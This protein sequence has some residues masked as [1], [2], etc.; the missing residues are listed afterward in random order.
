MIASNFP[1]G[2]YLVDFE[3][4]PAARREGNPP[5]PVCMVFRQWPSGDTKRYWQAGL[6]ALRA[7]PFPISSDAL[8]VAY[9]A[10]AE[11]DCFAALGW[12]YPAN[13][14]DL[15]AEFR[16]LTNGLRPA[17]GNSLL[18]ALLYFNLPTIGGEAKDAMRDLIRAGGPWPAAQQ[19]QILDYCESDVVGLAHLLTAMHSKIDL[20]RA[21]L[22]GRYMQSVSKMQVNGIPLDVQSMDLL[23]EKWLAIQDQLIVEIDQDYGVYS[24]R[25][26]KAEQW[27]AYLIANDIPWPRLPSGKLDLCDD[28]FRQMARSYAQVAPIREL[29]A[30]LSEMRLSNLYVGDDGRNRCLLS[31]FRAST[32][33]NQPSNSRFIFGPSVWLR[34]LIRPQP[35]WGLAYVDW[36][37]QE[38]GIAAALSQDAA[39]MGAYRSGDP[40]LAFAIQAGAVPKEATKKTHEA[41]REQF[42]QCV[43]AVQYGMGEVSLAARINQ[44]VAR[45]RQLLELHKRTYKQF[46]KWSDSAVDEAVLGGRLWTVFGWQIYATGEI[47]DRSLRNFPVQAT[48]ADMLRIACVLLTDAGIRVC[49]PV[50]DALLIEAPLEDLDEAVAITQALMKRAS[51]IVL[52]GFEL[53]SD[54]KE[55]RYPQRFMDKRGAQ[56]WDKVMRLIGQPAAH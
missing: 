53:G 33:R 40:Y 51:A 32:G 37:Q 45:A 24:G 54:V 44:P 34:G 50:H 17:H 7:A 23:A 6:Q 25:T 56:M 18:G 36:S 20:P 35:G 55:V 22:R 38:F 11:M 46:W 48:G 3:F 39:M 8:F 9:Y 13:L 43:L 30:S 42:K 49:A 21:L 27:E 47:N 26:F 10:S 2:I 31:P 19:A 5:V 28:I 15:F 4:H 14:L 41:Q 1:G 52:D 16:W 12:D 29:R